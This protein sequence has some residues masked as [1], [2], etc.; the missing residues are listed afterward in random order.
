MREI[1]KQYN[2]KSVRIAGFENNTFLIA[3]HDCAWALGFEDPKAEVM[4]FVIQE[5]YNEGELLDFNDFKVFMVEMKTIIKLAYRHNDQDKMVDFIA[6]LSL[7]LIDE[8]KVQHIEEIRTTY[9][10]SSFYATT[11]I[12]KEYGLSAA[13]LNQILHDHKVQFKVNKQ[14]VLY[15]DYQDKGLTSTFRYDK[16][17][18]SGNDKLIMHTYWTAKGVVFIENLLDRL[19]YRK[20]TQPNLFDQKV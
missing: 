7:K 11:Q 17:H 16:E 10:P 2:G 8:K 15:S 9:S 6:W 14:W 19:G 1:I 12:A 13:K 18:E 20:M 3:L 5:G 4:N